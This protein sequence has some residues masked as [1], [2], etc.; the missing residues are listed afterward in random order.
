MSRELWI[1]AGAVVVILG[2]AV[3]FIAVKKFRPHEWW[4]DRG[5]DYKVVD[6]EDFELHTFYAKG[7]DGDA[8]ALL[9]MHGGA[10]QFGTPAKMFPQCAFFARNGMHCFAVRY[11]VSGGG[12]PDVRGAIQDTRDAFDYVL[13]NA[14][15][16]GVDTSRIFVGGG[17]AGGH[18]A[19]AIGAGLP[20]KSAAERPAGLVLYN[21]M[22]DLA[23][24]MPD[25]TLVSD[26]WEEV[27]PLHH[28]DDRT[29]PALVLLGDRDT[30]I[31]VETAERFCAA[32]QAVGGQCEVAV[33]PG[34]GHGFF[35]YN[36][37]N[38][39]DFDSTNERV[40]G[41]LSGL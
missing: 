19:A 14:E 5:I 6:G 35:N 17:S 29:P 10:W 1:T 33:Y 11:R 31:S 40:L 28:L 15:K 18:L 34:R 23:P 13:A 37:G 26:Y 9:L 41:F 21:P 36:P 8:P 38:T 25:H 32:M 27:S 20:D 12:P 24:G 39:R 4:P 16:L 30:E 7:V 3:A 22:I 2:I